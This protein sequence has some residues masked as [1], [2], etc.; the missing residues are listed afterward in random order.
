MFYNVQRFAFLI[1]IN[2]FQCFKDWKES[3]FKDLLHVL[4][5]AADDDLDFN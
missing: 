2:S 5:V 1:F 3:Y 4:V